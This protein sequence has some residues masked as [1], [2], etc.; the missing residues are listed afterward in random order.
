[1]KMET[2]HLILTRPA[3]TVQFGPLQTELMHS[4]VIQPNGLTLMV[5][6]TVTNLSLQHKEIHVWLMQVHPSKI[7]LDVL[8]QTVMDIRMEI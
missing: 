1:M 8:I 6:G 5:M 2:V 3:S 7:D 4:W